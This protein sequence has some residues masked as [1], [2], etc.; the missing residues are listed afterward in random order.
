MIIAVTNLKGGVGKS[1]LSQNIAVGLSNYY[2]V[3]LVDTDT[4]QSSLQWFGVRELES[5]NLKA[6]GV[7]DSTALYKAVK[8][9]DADHDIIVIDGTPSL[10]KMTTSIILV[11]DLLLIPI[12]PGAHDIRSMDAFFER[13]H[14]AKEYKENIPAYFILNE[15]DDSRNLHK[16]IRKTLVETYDIPLFETT[17]KSRVAY[18]EAS[19]MGMSGYEQGDFR[20]KFE[21]I[22]LTKEVINKATEN[23]LLA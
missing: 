16:G 12:R 3:C 13:Y 22:G 1:T 11:S 7:T 14:Q 10:L 15:Y 5:P 8:S 19:V 2:K 9:L 18:G 4:N 23:G 21:M 20:T 17:I 6:V